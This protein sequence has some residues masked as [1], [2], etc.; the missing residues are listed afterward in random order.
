MIKLFFL[1]FFPT[2]SYLM[3]VPQNG[4]NSRFMD[5]LGWTPWKVVFLSIIDGLYYFIPGILL[6]I[7]GYYLTEKFK[8]SNQVILILI[9]LFM[10]AGLGLAGFG[11]FHLIYLIA[12]LEHILWTLIFLGI[13]LIV[14]I[15]LIFLIYKGILKLLQIGNS[16]YN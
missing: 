9:S 3:F 7:I 5:D 10:L 13:A 12:N 16:F 6:L 14:V 11:A 8:E 1:K 15:I 4:N 2:S